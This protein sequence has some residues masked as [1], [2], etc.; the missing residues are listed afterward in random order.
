MLC[1]SSDGP[2]FFQA[3]SKKR[4]DVSKLSSMVLESSVDVERDNQA[5]IALQDGQIDLSDRR[6]D[7]GEIQERLTKREVAL[8]QYLAD[9]AGQIVPRTEIF[10]EVWGYAPNVVSRAVDATMR[11]L[12]KKIEEDPADPK[13]L[14]STYGQ[15]YRFEFLPGQANEASAVEAAPKEVSRSAMLHQFHL[16]A[17]ETRLY[18]R[19]TEVA[20]MLAL[21]HEDCR[22]ITVMATGGMGKTR[23]AE[24][25]G[26]LVVYEGALPGGVW[27]CDLVE[28]RNVAEIVQ[29]VS[30][31]T[32]C[33]LDCGFRDPAAPAEL[34]RGMNGLGTALIILDNFE[35]I[36]QYAGE[37]VRVWAKTAPELRFLITSR[38]RLDLDG[39]RVFPL[40]PLSKEEAIELFLDRARAINPVFDST[41]QNSEIIGEIVD[42]LEGIPL[43]IQLAA[44]RA[45]LLSAKQIRNRLTQRFRLLRKGGRFSD[46]RQSTM[47]AA[48]DWSWNLLNEL[49]RTVLQQISVFRGGFTLAA[50]EAVVEPLAFASL[51]YSLADLLKGLA[52]KSMIFVRASELEASDSRLC[53]FDSIRYYALEKL[54]KAGDVAGA[55]ARHAAYY[56]R[57]LKVQNE[58]YQDRQLAHALALAR[59]EVDNCQ[60][61]F[62]RVVD[63]QPCLAL[64]LSLELKP[65]LVFEGWYDVG[66]SMAERLNARMHL[67]NNEERTQAHALH[68]AY[69]TEMRQFAA[70]RQEMDLALKCMPQ[71]WEPSAQHALWGQN[72]RLKMFERDYP[73]MQTLLTRMEEDTPAKGELRA[74]VLTLRAEMAMRHGKMNEA[75]ELFESAWRVGGGEVTT[76]FRM[77]VRSFQGL[78]RC[79][80]GD[81]KGGRLLIEEMH[82]HRRRLG[83]QTDIAVDLDNLGQIDLLLGD[84][85]GAAVRFQESVGIWHRAGH[86]AQRRHQLM[87]LALAHQLSGEPGAA[88]NA[89][90]WAEQGLGDQEPLFG[91]IQ[92]LRAGLC[93]M[94]QQEEE[95]RRLWSS[96]SECLVRESVMSAQDVERLGRCHFDFVAEEALALVQDPRLLI[97]REDTGAE[98][99]GLDESGNHRT[100]VILLEKRLGVPPY[101]ESREK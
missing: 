82:R 99:Q 58:Q 28:A 75:A 10:T 57:W 35:Q 85:R 81:L 83:K 41:G 2:D 73:G 29:V 53:T 6:V 40:E 90:D 17:A 33:P 48:I 19:R 94:W 87:Y 47:R 42:S 95:G 24:E 62:E 80:K 61:V 13:H 22:L 50:A 21:L 18:G 5:L 15:G 39:E 51:P 36:A 71:D 20:S 4:S 52:D 12:R 8:L 89:L 77:R 14:F 65:L 23:L 76:R 32:G 69:L 98:I 49:E 64:Q 84:T 63:T 96:Y 43:A 91:L 55:E 70:S 45:R 37:T 68:A 100:H 101:A 60:M 27:F 11:R 34:G 74:N 88:A 25:V 78:I 30:N 7:R 66:L 3:R 56:T 79:L 92:C 38:Q 1:P 59:Q 86:D 46:G 44:G 9:R 97:V 54:E 16:G 26:R 31:A 67:L 72:A 93:G